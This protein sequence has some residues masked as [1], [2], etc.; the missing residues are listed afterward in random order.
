MGLIKYLIAA[1]LACIVGFVVYVF[2]HLGVFKPVSIEYQEI[3]TFYLLAIE[4]LGPYHKI[5][6]SILVVEKFAQENKI[7]CLKTFGMFLDDPEKVEEVRLRSLV[8]CVVD[9]EIK[10][11]PSQFKMVVREKQN[12]VKASFEGSPSISPYKVYPKAME[13]IQER[14][15]LFNGEVI[16]IYQIQPGENFKTTY[17]FPIKSDS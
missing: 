3:D 5:L 9:R 16:E 1:G 7:N 11:L 6:D 13:L 2:V 10:E 8:G 17:L 4:N 12:Y 15:L 14:R